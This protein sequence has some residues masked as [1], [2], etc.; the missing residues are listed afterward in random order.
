MAVLPV[1]SILLI[2]VCI[3]ASDGALDSLYCEKDNCYDRK[4]RLY[5]WKS[6]KDT[7]TAWYPFDKI[8]R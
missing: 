1:Y 2:L 4:F 6:L 3:T 8:T 5:S 7:L